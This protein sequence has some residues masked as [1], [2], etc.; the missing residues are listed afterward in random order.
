MLIA[1]DG[2]V[3]FQVFRLISKRKHGKRGR[4]YFTGS[5]F[6]AEIISDF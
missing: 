5:A 3:R 4:E 1:D 2:Y 6:P